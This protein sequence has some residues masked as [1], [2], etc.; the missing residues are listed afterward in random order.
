[1]DDM[2]RIWIEKLE[3]GGRLIGEHSYA[4][5]EALMK[6]LLQKQPAIVEA[7]YVLG[8]A[9]MQQGRYDE[10]LLEASRLRELEPAHRGA[11]M[12]RTAKVHV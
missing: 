6:A 12:I 5:A 4:A 7:R 10:A 1:M 11:A 3:L 2:S 9:L 8:M